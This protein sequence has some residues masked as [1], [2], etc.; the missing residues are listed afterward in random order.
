MNKLRTIRKIVTGK[1]TVDGAGVKLVRVIGRDDTKEFDPFLMLDAFDS[2]DPDDYIKGFPWHPHRGIETITYL[3]QGEIEHG[4]SL[5]NTGR[6]LTGECQW[7]T[8]GAGILHQEM[9]KASERML[10]VQLWLNLPAKDK[11]VPPKYHGIRKEDIPVIDEGDRQIH[12][13][14]GIYGGKTGAMEGEY[15]KP[16]LLDVEVR[17]G[18]EWSLAIA[19]NATLFIYIFQGA[20]TFGSDRLIP[21]KHAVL[22]DE[23][24]TFLVRA[25]NEGIRFF[26]MAGEMLQEPIAWGGPI[27]MNTREELQLA[28]RELEEGKFIKS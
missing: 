1:H 28:F 17:A 7:M 2:V 19:A 4:D 16:L 14:S 26:L 3:I 23:T 15:C 24:G 8:A 11:M 18:A 9:P 22:F 25:S 27:V 20:G 21:A 10:G 6:I 13:L 12:I 5:G